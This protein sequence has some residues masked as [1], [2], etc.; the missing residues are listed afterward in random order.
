M[1][2][3]QLICL[4][5]NYDFCDMKTDININ[6][7]DDLIIVNTFEKVVKFE[8]KKQ[9]FFRGWH[10]CHPV[11][12]LRVKTKHMI[13][14]LNVLNDKCSNIYSR[15]VDHQGAVCAIHNPYL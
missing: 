3:T 10:F 13:L 2:I 5:K 12:T 14:L 8:I 6:L 9:V 1:P 15:E 11:G 4:L 7:L